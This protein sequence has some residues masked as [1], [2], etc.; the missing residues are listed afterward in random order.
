MVPVPLTGGGDPTVVEGAYTQPCFAHSIYDYCGRP[1]NRN[2]NYTYSNQQFLFQE[3][4]GFIASGYQLWRLENGLAAPD[5]SIYYCS[6]PTW[7]TLTG[8]YEGTTHTATECCPG[9]TYVEC[10]GCRADEVAATLESGV[11]CAGRCPDHPDY[12]EPYTGPGTGGEDVCGIC[13]G[14]G[15]NASGCC[16]EQVKDC[17]DNCV[18]P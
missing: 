9:Y 12:T 6:C 8:L 10:H 11:D 14:P 15:L 3:E 16:G 17:N 5:D 1:Y 4:T 7:N 2:E 18:D 13:D